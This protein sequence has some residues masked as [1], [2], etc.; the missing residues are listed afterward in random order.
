MPQRNE[1][2]F[3]SLAYADPFYRVEFYIRRSGDVMAEA[4][5]DAQPLPVQQKF[6]SLFKWMGDHGR[7]FNERKFKHL[8]GSDQIFEFKSGDGRVLCFFFT[9]KRI[10]LTHGFKK[11]GDNTP[12]GE[13][14][15]AEKI[16]IE[17]E[18]RSKS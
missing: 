14:E 3:V 1:K 2:S 9:G 17:F 13:I 10:V 16:K 15:M 7:I 12:K 18:E 6:A 5:L 11:K 4:W 8:T